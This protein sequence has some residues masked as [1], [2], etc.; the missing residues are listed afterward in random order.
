[1]AA[2]IRPCRTCHAQIEFVHTVK[3]KRIPLDLSTPVGR[4]NIDLNEDGLAEV[5]PVGTGARI[6][7]WATCPDAAKFRRPVQG[8]LLP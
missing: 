6:S 5:V 4:G 1:M 7:H 3:G 8:R 2:D